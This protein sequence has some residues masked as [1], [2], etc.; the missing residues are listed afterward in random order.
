MSS[1]NIPRVLAPEELRLKIEPSTLGFET[2]QEW[3]RKDRPVLPQKRAA[4]ALQFGLGVN[5]SDFNIY[6]AG[7][8]ETGLLDMAIKYVENVAKGDGQKQYDWCYVYNFKNPDAPLAVRLPKGMGKVF[9]KEMADF[10][11]NLRLHIPKVFEGETYLTRK[12]DVIRGFNQERNQIFEELEKKVVER[13]FSLQA[14]QSGM[15]VIP[16]NPDGSFMTP[17]DIAKL[18]EEE[19]KRLKDISQELHKEMGA[20]MRR[21]HQLEQGVSERLRDLDRELV[22]QTCDG[23]MVD[24]LK[25]YGEHE[26]LAGYLADCRE[27]VIKNMDDF[28]PKAAAHTP[29]PF[30]GMAPSFIQYEVNVIVDNEATS[31][32]PVI[33]ESNPSYPNLFGAVEKR[34]QMGALFTDF[35][36]I[37]AGA[38]HR[39]NGGF[40]ILKAIDLLKWPFSYEALKR[41]LR[42]KKLEIEDPAEQYGLFTTK[43]LKPGSIPL[44]VKVVLVGD[45]YLYQILYNYDED[46]RSL[47]KVKAHMETDMPL[48][49]ENL[50]DFLGVLCEIVDGDVF[51][52]L[53][54]TAVARLIE[55]GLEL[56]GSQEKLTLKT[57]ELSD[58][59]READFWARQNNAVQMRDIHVQQAIDE[60][61]RRS[62]LVEDRI[63]ELL[64]KDVLK[65]QT[66][67]SVTGQVNGL[68]VYDLGDYTF[69]KPTRITANIALGKDGVINIERE[70][71]LSG[72]IHTKGVMILAGYL[73]SRFAR[74]R[75]LTLSAT[76]CFEQNYGMVDGDSASGAELF[77]LL[78]ALADVPVDQGKAV[79]GAVSQKG[80]ML[81]IGGV[82]QKIEGFFDLCDQR[83]LIGTQGVLIPDANV[84]DLMLKQRVVDAVREGRFHIWPISTVEEGL[85]LLTGLPAGRLEDDGTWTK[86]SLFARVDARLEELAQA[87]KSLESEKGEK[88]A[89][90]GQ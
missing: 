31:G 79:T 86:D 53:H 23:V 29:F 35:T 42:D 14:D 48:T 25:K 24:L 9:K 72:N 45:S 40:L 58:L 83:G 73:R 43:T 12:E 70:S 90:N 77:A 20:A 64:L 82:N 62:C 74:K 75:P 2:L 50:E 5:H 56:A 26:V 46:F 76:L 1:Q 7:P 65:V 84:K 39:A 37:K 80:E 87:A 59:L 66:T 15:M 63:Q 78:S 16:N 47:F 89:E 44:K 88:Q 6:I 28:R 22:G 85:L 18:S 4:R 10:L 30:P 19:Q 52:P 21:V 49:T 71:S 33:I 67:G 69:G 17:E 61:I 51:L 3:S 54:N 55:Y 8:K 34:A 11:E 60:K 36:M 81:P 68:A 32:A 57:L 27:D 13:G 38:L 41:A